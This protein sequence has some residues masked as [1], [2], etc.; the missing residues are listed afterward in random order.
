MESIG[1]KVCKEIV[2]EDKGGLEA[3]EIWQTLSRSACLKAPNRACD[4]A[5]R[6]VRDRNGGG[7]Y[8]EIYR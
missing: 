4:V 5:T 2:L 6:R 8:R 1:R 3:M 7:L